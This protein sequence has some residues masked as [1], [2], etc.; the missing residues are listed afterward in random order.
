M[1]LTQLDKEKAGKFHEVHKERPFH[2]ELVA[3]I[4]GGPVVASCL[5]ER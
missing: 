1:K 2:D 4:T 3:Y 5:R